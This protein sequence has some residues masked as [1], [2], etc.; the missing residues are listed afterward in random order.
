[1]RGFAGWFFTLWSVLAAMPRLVFRGA[2]TDS[3]ALG[4]EL[5][6]MQRAHMSHHSACATHCGTQQAGNDPNI[7]HLSRASEFMWRNL[8]CDLPKA[9]RKDRKV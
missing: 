6:C 4:I 1:M 9:F 7:Q 5:T 8:K 3:S 2:H